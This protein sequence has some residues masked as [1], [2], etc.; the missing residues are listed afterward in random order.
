MK[1]AF[2]LI[3]IPFILSLGS[4]SKDEPG[5]PMEEEPGPAPSIAVEVISNGTVENSNAEGANLVVSRE[6][7][8]LKLTAEIPNDYRSGTWNGDPLGSSVSNL[9]VATDR[10][11]L[12]FQEMI[13]SG[14][15]GDE[16]VVKITDDEGLT[17]TFTISTNFVNDLESSQI[18]P[19]SWS[20]VSEAGDEIGWIFATADNA[21]L[22]NRS[23][24]ITRSTDNGQTDASTSGGAFGSESDIN[25]IAQHPSGDL[26]VTEFFGTGILKSTDNGQ[27]WASLATNLPTGGASI[28]NIE[29]ASDGTFYLAMFNFFGG[30]GPQNGVWSSADGITWELKSDQLNNQNIRS[31]EIVDENTLVAG[32]DFPGGRLFLSTDKGMSWTKVHEASSPTSIRGLLAASDGNIYAIST[33]G[34]LISVDDGA[35]FQAFNTGL[36][37]DSTI[38]CIIE[39]SNG[40]IIVTPSNYGA[41]VLEND[42][43]KSIGTD[44]AIYDLGSLAELNDGLYAAGTPNRIFSLD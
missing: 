24:V 40:D 39:L 11:S 3:L 12:S 10:K 7:F 44:V 37:A 36:P 16:V 26:Y 33:S 28:W 35:S 29:I 5:V 41:F 4:C 21:L 32:T 9:M 43:W 8:M 25:D 14:Y 2:W 19:G 31:L 23:G 30:P 6:G 13:Y 22:F 18:G 27:S 1:N 34:V 20:L 42:E 17:T 15:S 38:G